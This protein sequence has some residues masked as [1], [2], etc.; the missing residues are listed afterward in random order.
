VWRAFVF[1]G[2]IYFS[3][4]MAVFVLNGM[5]WPQG[6]GA[7]VMLVVPSALLGAIVTSVLRRMRWRRHRLPMLLVIHTAAAL[8]FSGTSLWLTGL[9]RGAYAALGGG[10]WTIIWPQ[11]A[12]LRFHLIL[13]TLVYA[14]LVGAMYAWQADAYARQEQARRG[15][16][17]ELQTRAELQALR[18]Q[19]N[20]HFLLNTLHA[21]VALMRRDVGEA[22]RAVE[23]LAGLL[24]YVLRMHREGD[25]FATVGQEWKFVQQYLAL[26]Q[27]RFGSRLRVNSSCDPAAANAFLPVLTIQPLVENALIHG[28]APRTAGGTVDLHVDLLTGNEVRVVVIND[29]PGTSQLPREAPHGS[30]L[31]VIRQRMAALYGHRGR[32]VAG[33]TKEG[34]FKVEI[35][36]PA[37]PT[38]SSADEGRVP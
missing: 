15:R 8:P 4:L 22:E 23:E 7:S 16:A 17:E 29:L 2:L 24:A 13:G 20:P 37:D 14:V 18:S 34:R 26:E 28:V 10:E 9:L 36:V 38:Q 11:G 12:V 1:G 33:A 35:N 19:L 3:V 32:V 5:P 27:R 31:A 25:E 6:A 21:I 30:G